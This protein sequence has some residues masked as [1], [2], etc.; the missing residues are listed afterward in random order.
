MSYLIYHPKRKVSTF[1]TVT[2]YYD[3]PSGNQDPYVWNRSFLHTYC[4]IT[5]M[6]PEE[7]DINFWV[8]GDTFPSFTSMFCDLV[9]V[10]REKTYWSTANSIDRQDP[11][12]DSD[13]AY[14]DHYLWA[15]HQHHLRR[16]RRFTLKADPDRSFQPQT[17]AGAL[18]DIAGRLDE[19]GVSRR[20]LRKEMR[21]GTASRPFRLD[22]DVAEGLYDWLERNAKRKLDG[23]AL[24][25]VRKDN[26]ELASAAPKAH[27]SSGS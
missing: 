13:E 12:V 7:G 26:P 19:L 2:V 1:G 22:K 5:Q 10:V 18:I 21:A 25:K 9:F 16:R 4:H 27:A 8:S 17:R 3:T 6:T 15:R 11:M 24:A 20:T 23:L 14:A